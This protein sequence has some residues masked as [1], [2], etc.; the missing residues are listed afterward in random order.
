[1]LWLGPARDVP[2]EFGCA[3]LGVNEPCL[4]SYMY[5]VI[6]SLTL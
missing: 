5:N 1:M 4:L 3:Q 6:F 2:S